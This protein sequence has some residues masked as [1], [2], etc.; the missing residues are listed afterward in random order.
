MYHGGPSSKEWATAT[1]SAWMVINDNDA[2]NA[3]FVEASA[4]P[5]EPAIIGY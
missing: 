2:R 1:K 3:I 4:E 5:A